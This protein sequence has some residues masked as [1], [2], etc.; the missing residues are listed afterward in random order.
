[1]TKRVRYRVE[2]ANLQADGKHVR[3][4]TEWTGPHRGLRDPRHIETL[5]EQQAR[6]LRDDLVEVLANL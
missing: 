5:T 4:I 2:E 1:M 6:E 3:L